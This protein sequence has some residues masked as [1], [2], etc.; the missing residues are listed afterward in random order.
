MISA[1]M[2]DSC[3]AARRLHNLARMTHQFETL[4]DRDLSS[5]TGGFNL[6]GVLQSISG[7]TGSASGIIGGIKGLI[8]SFKAPRGGGEPAQ[9]Q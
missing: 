6:Q 7:I 9:G 1:R 8:Q 3:T 5:A 2:R 4:T